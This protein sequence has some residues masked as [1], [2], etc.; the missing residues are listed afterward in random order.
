MAQGFH[1]ERRI[2]SLALNLVVI[3]L[4]MKLPFE[5]LTNLQSFVQHIS[6]FIFFRGGGESVN[7]RNTK[8]LNN[9][10]FLREISL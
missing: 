10:V 7:W 9:F 3:T 8:V 2:G 6:P 5:Y 4:N 1:F